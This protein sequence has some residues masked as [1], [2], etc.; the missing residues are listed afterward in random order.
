MQICYPCQD[1]N[2]R[3]SDPQ[4]PVHLIWNKREGGRDRYDSM[5][6]VISDLKFSLSF[7]QAQRISQNLGDYVVDKK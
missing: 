7:S 3:M 4:S 6:L 5:C 1:Q 2:H